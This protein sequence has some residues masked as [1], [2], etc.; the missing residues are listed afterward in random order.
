MTNSSQRSMLPDGFM[1]TRQRGHVGLCVIVFASA[2]TSV[3]SLTPLTSALTSTPLTEVADESE[4]E[5]AAEL[6]VEEAKIDEREEIETEL[7][8]QCTHS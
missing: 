6:E 3:L 2:I 1:L 4:N 5:D 7:G 8:K